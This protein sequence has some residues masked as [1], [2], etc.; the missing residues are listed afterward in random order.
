MLLVLLPPLLLL[1]LLLPLLLPLLLVAPSPLP[2]RQLLTWRG[3]YRGPPFCAVCDGRYTLPA[4]AC[5]GAETMSLGAMCGGWADEG[6]AGDAAAAEGAAAAMAGVAVVAV[7]V[8]AT[9]TA[10]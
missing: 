10:I 1:A 8:A 6:W 9:G 4:L 2:D 3:M 7:A 5:T